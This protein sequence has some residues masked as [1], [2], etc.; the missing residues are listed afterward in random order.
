MQT[1]KP[2]NQVVPIRKL[3]DRCSVGLH[4]RQT[5]WIEFTAQRCASTLQKGHRTPTIDSREIE[6][7][8]SNPLSVCV[9][10]Q[11]APRNPNTLSDILHCQ[12]AFSGVGRRHNTESSEEQGP[13]H[14]NRPI[15]P[16]CRGTACTSCRCRRGKGRCGRPSARR[17]SGWPG[18]FPERRC[19][20]RWGGCS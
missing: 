20:P 4:V 16:A 11:N 14:Q 9:S 17:P 10:K 19:H 18:R 8:S 5:R 13:A 12:H 7:A 6:M 2:E 15:K 1:S 3:N